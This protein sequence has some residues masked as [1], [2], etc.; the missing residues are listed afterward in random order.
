MLP[1]VHNYR[2]LPEIPT[3]INIGSSMAN[4]FAI[5]DPV[6]DRREIF[7]K[8]ISAIIAPVPGLAIASCGTENFQAIWAAHPQ[9]PMSYEIDPDGL[10]IVWGE[11]IMPGTATRITAKTLKNYWQDFPQIFDGFHACLTYDPDLGITVSADLLGIFP[12]YYYVDQEIVLVASS[13]ELFKYHPR[14][15]AKFNPKGLVGILLT[16]GLFNG[17][18]LWQGIYRLKAGY[19]LKIVDHQPKEIQQYQLPSYDQQ[20]P[21]L[22]ISLEEHL[23]ILDR[24]ISQALD[25]QLQPA[26]TYNLML[27][28]GLDSRMLA[29]FMT[30]QGIKPTALTLGNYGDVEMHCAQGVAQYLNLAHTIAPTEVNKYLE[31]AHLANKWEHLANGANGIAIGWGIIPYLQKL[32]PKLVTGLCLDVAFSGPLPVANPGET[33]SFDLFLKR[34][35]NSWAISPE[36]LQQLLRKE[37]FGD[38]VKETLAEIQQVYEGYSTSE[39]TRNICFEYYHRSRFHTGSRAW[40]FSF[41]AAPILPILDQEI[42]SINNLLP[43]REINRLAQQQLV[44]TRFPALA[45]LPIDRNSYD[46]TPLLGSQEAG[47]KARLRRKW[48]QLQQYWYKFQENI[49]YDR[50][51]YYKILDINNAGWRSIRQEAESGRAIAGEIFDLDILSKILPLANLRITSHHNSIIE[52]SK[53]KL[54]ATFLLWA[55]NNW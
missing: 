37:I 25:H 44:M 6:S 22:D 8:T 11:A 18:T 19:C 1:L 23:D 33:F 51:Y 36:I 15:Q 50:R 9:S 32:P 46:I 10:A 53:V 52:S 38:L 41:G 30:Q 14:Y 4:F 39:Y 5:A 42:L 28:G 45:K 24:L 12:V 16:N 26:E 48:Y 31:Y 27:S 21:Y 34:Q 3:E 13:P 7:I 49:G 54:L 40:I 17:Q 43:M 2:L 35:I 29:G 20:N 55:N 47:K